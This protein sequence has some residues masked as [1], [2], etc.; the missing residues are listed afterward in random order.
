MSEAFQCL[1][2]ATQHALDLAELTYKTCN[3]KADANGKPIQTQNNY[4]CV[5]FNNLFRRL[6]EIKSKENCMINGNMDES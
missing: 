6:E 4:V 1:V 3:P 5:C 2:D